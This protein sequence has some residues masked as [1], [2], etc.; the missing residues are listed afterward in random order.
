M[1]NTYTLIASNTLGSAAS[2][3]S[4]SSIPS[5]YDDLLLKWSARSAASADP[6]YVSFNDDSS[7]IYNRTNFRSNASATN[8]GNDSGAD[9]ISI[10]GSYVRSTYTS[11]TF[12]NVE[13]YIPSYR[14]TLNKS[15]YVYGVSE[16]NAATVDFIAV[17]S[18][19]YENSTAITKITING[20][21]GN[22]DTNSSFYLYGIK[23]T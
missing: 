4:F 15:I 12:S 3:L 13:L 8:S 5:T 16:N 1:A 11:S 23:N 9:S 2:S 20:K 10:Q 18:G 14:S 17:T 22:I 7:A 19:L 21:F 6:L